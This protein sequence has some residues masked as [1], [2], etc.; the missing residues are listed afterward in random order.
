MNPSK[1][2]ANL[3]CLK[4]CGWSCRFWETGSGTCSSVTEH[5]SLEIKTSQN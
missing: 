5:S 4:D 3:L 2:L 1:L